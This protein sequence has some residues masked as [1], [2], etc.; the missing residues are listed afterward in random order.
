[1]RLGS[2]WISF[3]L[4]VLC[5]AF[6]A[7]GAHAVPY[8][9]IAVDSAGTIGGGEFLQASTRSSRPGMINSFLHI[10][11]DGLEQDDGADNRPTSVEPNGDM[12]RSSSIE[13]IPVVEID[14]TDYRESLIE[15]SQLPT[16][17]DS[18]LAPDQYRIWRESI[19]VAIGHATNPSK[20]IHDPDAQWHHGSLSDVGLNHASTSAAG[21]SD[22]PDGL[23]I[24]LNSHLDLF[25]RLDERIPSITDSQARAVRESRTN[26]VIPK[27]ATLAL[28]GIGLAGMGLHKRRRKTSEK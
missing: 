27:S 16:G 6:L 2:F 4:T 3:L 14:E 8:A 17:N 12:T 22:D 11:T 28:M 23:F 21:T 18:T 20:L 13:D 15:I 19:A 1:M 10:R 7:K 24:A 25:S 5:A 26:P 9:L